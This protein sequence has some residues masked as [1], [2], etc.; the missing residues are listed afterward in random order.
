MP[1]AKT[2]V[3]F[4]D[5]EILV[6]HRPGASDWTLVTF[7]DLT[8]RPSG[9]AFWARGAAEKLD[10]DAIG[11]VAKREN[12]YPAA[13]VERAAPAVHAALKPRSIAYGYSMG[14]YGALKHGRCLGLAGAIAV[15]PQ[16]SVSPADVPWDTRFHRLHQPSLHQGMIVTAAD[17]APFVAVLADPYDGLD[18]RH[19]RMAA[20][21]GRAHLLR[22]PMTGH[23][24]IW[25]LAGSRALEEIL[26]PALAHDIAGMRAVLRARRARSGHWF[27][28]MGRA[29]ARHGHDRLSETLWQRAAELGMPAALIEVERAEAM[30]DRAYRLVEAG[31]PAEAVA[32]CRRLVAIENRPAGSIGRA[33][34]VLLKAGVPAEAEAAF[35]LALRD[36]SATPDLHIGL[37]LALGQQGRG[38][39]AIE[40][41][42]A[43]HAALPRDAE[44]A[45]HLGHLLIGAG[46]DHQAEAEAAF[47]SVLARQPASGQALYG[48]SVLTAGRGDLP[49]ARLLAQRAVFRMPGNQDALAWLAELQLRLG[50]AT[51]AARLFRGVVQSDPS[52]ASAH[53]GLSEALTALGRREEAVAA[54]R[55]GL[56]ALPDDPMLRARLRALTGPRSVPA[57]LAARLLRSLLPRLAQ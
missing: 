33:G 35:R 9:A 6:L 54:V 26:A 29:A 2:R 34:H 18:W 46:G 20:A 19:A 32:Q 55:R 22:A 25:L 28:L 24:A 57:R 42:R 4:E 16:V 3:L 1:P 27:R 40:V 21:T 53:A 23:G 52:R 49:K 36:R 56:A 5:R 37:S 7:A 48:M 12:W 11:F 17:L 30:A 43:A 47:R 44:I 38:R 15:A 10:L 8:F 14:A 50:D 51:R 39:E 31:R 41:A 13:S 45:T